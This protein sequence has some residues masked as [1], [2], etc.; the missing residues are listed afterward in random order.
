MS[1]PV[2]SIETQSL[3]AKLRQKAV[4]GTLTQEEMKLAVKQMRGD[5]MT[6]VKSSSSKTKQA[7]AVIPD[8]DDML[9]ELE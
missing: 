7:K 9:K 5:R 8:A 6:A 2:Q 3:L 4:E 1:G